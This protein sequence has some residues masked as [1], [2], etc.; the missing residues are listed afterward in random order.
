VPETA[1]LTG[2]PENVPLKRQASRVVGG[3]KLSR[4]RPLE[5]LLNTVQNTAG[6][7]VG[8]PNLPERFSHVIAVDLV[9]RHRSEG[10]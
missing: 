6:R 1:T 3:A 2:R 10:W 8:P 9:D 7:G 5:N 4:D